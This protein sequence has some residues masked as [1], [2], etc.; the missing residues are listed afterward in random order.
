MGDL[1]DAANESERAAEWIAKI[2]A[3]FWE[4]GIEVGVVIP[5][6]VKDGLGTIPSVGLDLRAIA[7]AAEEV[8]LR[9]RLGQ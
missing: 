1:S 5:E 3:R 2:A 9:I 8:K 4:K 7:E 6:Q